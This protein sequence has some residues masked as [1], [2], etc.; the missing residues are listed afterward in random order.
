MIT[1]REFFLRGASPLLASLLVPTGSFGDELSDKFPE[2][3]NFLRQRMRLPA[4]AAV[5]TTR[6]QIIAQSESGRNRIDQQTAVSPSA[7]WQLGSITTTFTATLT[8]ILVEKGKLDWDTKLSGIYPELTSRMAP[9]VGQITIR[10]VIEHRSGMGGDA[11]PWEGAPEF[12]QPGLTLSQRRQRSV[13]L[14]LGAPLDFEPGSRY[15]YS[16][17]A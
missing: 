4:I 15:Q 7:H 3:L 12:N 17:R 5:I 1:R 14:A 2:I 9:N 6:D 16:N 10:N 13:P 8:A 11:F